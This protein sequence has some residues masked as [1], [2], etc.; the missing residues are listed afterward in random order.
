MRKVEKDF[1]KRARGPNEEAYE[2]TITLKF[3]ADPKLDFEQVREKL[4]ELTRG[5]LDGLTM[6][7]KRIDTR[8]N[9]TKV[10]LEKFDY[11]WEK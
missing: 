2:A 9:L 7:T 11:G 8:M 1:L 10:E 3:L 5:S 6:P 4:F